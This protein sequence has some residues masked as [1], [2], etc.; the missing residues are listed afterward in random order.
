MSLSS[1]LQH[2]LELQEQRAK[3]YSRLHESFKTMIETKIEDA[4]LELI[5]EITQNFAKISKEIIAIENQLQQVLR[6]STS[7]QSCLI[8]G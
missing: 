8:D 5:P 6:H 7:P 3:E 2:F 4:F 1:L